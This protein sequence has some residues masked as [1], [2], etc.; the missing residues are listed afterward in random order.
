[1][2]FSFNATNVAPATGRPDPVPAG[3]Y[4]L[5]IKNADVETN[6]NGVQMIKLDQV[7]A[8]GPFANRKVWQRITLSHPTST[9]AERIGQA[10]F[11]SLCH[12]IGVLQVQDT[13]QLIN[14]VARARLKVRK[15]ANYG[16]SNEVTAYEAV[17]GGATSVSAA[18]FPPAASHLAQPVAAPAPAA[19]AP[20]MK[21]TA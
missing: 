12:A 2:Q 19:V 21:K 17:T 20:W 4:T 16:D 15:D 1:M 7:I 9:D 18:G 10:L 5:I 8:D 3:V 13:T 6:A 14:K 11:S